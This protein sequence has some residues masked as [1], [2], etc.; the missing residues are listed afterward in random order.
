MTRAEEVCI[1]AGRDAAN[2]NMRK[3]GR[4]KWNR[5]DIEI[6][7]NVTNYLTKK[8]EGRHHLVEENQP[9][10]GWITTTIN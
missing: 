6:A 3:D 10:P 9:F 1:T 8:M 4:R 5:K 7:A 2:I